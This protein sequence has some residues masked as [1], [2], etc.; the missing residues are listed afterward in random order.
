MCYYLKRHT[1]S[2]IFAIIT[3]LV[4]IWIFSFSAQSSEASSEVSFGVSRFLAELFVPQI[5]GLSEQLREEKIEA[6]VPI[7]RKLAHFFV[8]SALGLFAS[9]TG[10]CFNLERGK[11]TNARAFLFDALF[12]FIYACSDEFHQLFVSGRYA[13]FFDVF[14]DFCGSVLGILFAAFAFWIFTKPR[15]IKN[16]K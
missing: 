9:L 4:S 1:A 3:L 16:A 2:I 14:I 7:I 15:K 10:L 13:S 11:K 8:F 5:K 12:C 6:L